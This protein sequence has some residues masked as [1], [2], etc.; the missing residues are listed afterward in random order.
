MTIRSGIDILADTKCRT[1]A[2]TLARLAHLIAHFGR[3]CET[4]MNSPWCKVF[5]QISKII[6]R[7]FFH[8][9]MVVMMLMLLLLLPILLRTLNGRNGA[10]KTKYKYFSHMSVCVFE[11]ASGRGKAKT[12]NDV[13]AFV[14]HREWARPCWGPKAQLHTART[15]ES[16]ARNINSHSSR[17]EV[18]N[19]YTITH[20]RHILSY[21]TE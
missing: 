4:Y 17:H 20:F 9:V 5:H 12:E 19:A 1:N 15:L 3:M 8:M 7:Y 18:F 11:Y 10:H 16:M 14:S 21:H 13:F 6:D 2:H